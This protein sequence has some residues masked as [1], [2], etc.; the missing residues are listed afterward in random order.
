MSSQLEDKNKS[1]VCYQNNVQIIIDKNKLNVSE[2]ET[3]YK[4]E[5]EVLEE[6]KNTM[7]SLAYN[8]EVN[9]EYLIIKNMRIK[10]IL[11][12]TF[13][14]IF[15]RIFNIIIPLSLFYHLLLFIFCLLFSPRKTH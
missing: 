5:R 10:Y 12:F 1:L 9:K 15:N 13:N 8:E 6:K 11:C 7:T 4:A 14:I 3:S 2:M